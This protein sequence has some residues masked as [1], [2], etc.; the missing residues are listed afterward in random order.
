MN[1]KLLMAAA[2]CLALAAGLVVYSSSG[3]ARKRD[4][5][6]DRKSANER[7]NDRESGRDRSEA[8]D[9]EEEQS[10]GVTVGDGER[11][12]GDSEAGKRSSAGGARAD[13]SGG[14]SSGT[15]DE[16]EDD[17]DTRPSDS[18]GPADYGY[19][20]KK[21]DCS[22]Y[23]RASGEYKR[24]AKMADD[25]L[26]SAN[27]I[28]MS[29][30]QRMGDSLWKEL[31]K[32]MGSKLLDEGPEVDYV[33]SIADK[34]VPYVKRGAAKYTFYVVRDNSV[35]AFSMAGGYVVIN[36]G[37]INDVANEAQLAMVIGH[38]IAH[39]DLKHSI[40]NV[41]LA[42]KLL[43]GI[44]DVTLTL[45]WVMRLP[46]SSTQELEA[47]QWG[48]E[49]I[50]KAGYSPFQGPAFMDRLPAS[51]PWSEAFELPISF[52]DPIID[53]WAKEIARMFLDEVQSMFETHPSSAERSCRM[54]VWLYDKYHGKNN[55]W[56]YVG[57]AGI[58]KARSGF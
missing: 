12:D 43:G 34:I 26:V 7:T 41:L 25:A 9:Q 36:T 2:V 22:K 10:G 47:D 55:K 20:K 54:R 19:V 28:S 44:T 49:M 56:Y 23:Q 6:G 24:L 40:S 1:G 4:R 15:G 58:K 31:Q 14:N 37:L 5:S 48:M 16:D 57:E 45:V 33:R 3:E 50:M 42:E 17:V 38:E 51:E 13:R 8:G 53:R 46:L 27:S 32:Q 18:D 29:E 21:S 35:N 11:S 30:E 39:N 52:G